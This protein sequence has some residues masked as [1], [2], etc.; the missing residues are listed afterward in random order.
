MEDAAAPGPVARP[1]AKAGSYRILEDVGAYAAQALLVV[2]DAR[3]EALL[4]EVTDP[5]VAA[6]E[7]LRVHAVEPVHAVGQLLEEALDHEVEV[8]V[9]EAVRVQEPAEAVLRVDDSGDD[10]SAVVIVADDQLPRDAANGDVERGVL[11]ELS[12]IHI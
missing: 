11:R 4:I 8:I 10:R 3:A 2:D 5:R 1:G 6:V 12:L 7:P 9:E